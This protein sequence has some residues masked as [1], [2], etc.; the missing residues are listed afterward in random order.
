VLI[1]SGTKQEFLE[2]RLWQNLYEP[3]WLGMLP[4]CW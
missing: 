3:T 2:R 1:E 4:T